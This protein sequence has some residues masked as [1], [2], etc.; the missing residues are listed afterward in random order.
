MILRT[1]LGLVLIGSVAACA[2]PPDKLSIG[3]TSAAYS[4]PPAN[5]EW[6]VALCNP[7]DTPAISAG[8]D[9]AFYSQ[10]FGGTGLGT[11]PHYWMAQSYFQASINS[12]LTQWI[13][14]GHARAW[15]QAQSR[16]TNIETCVNAALASGNYS[17]FNF[18]NY[19]AVYNGQLDEGSTTANIQGKSLPA[20][21]LDAYSP[22]SAIFHEMGHG[23]GLGH[24]YNDQGT[25]YGDPYD[26]MSAMNVYPFASQYCVSTGGW[27]ACDSGPGLNAWTRRQL[28]WLLPAQRQL[29]WPATAGT[30]LRTQSVALAP[31]NE[32]PIGT[33]QVL[34]I[35]A[36]ASYMYTV[37]WIL[38]DNYDLGNLYAANL[39]TQPSRT[40]TNSLVIHK[41]NYGDQTTYL[42]TGAG[43][44]QTSPGN[45]FYDSATG[46]HIAL[47]GTSFN[48]TVQVT[49]D[50]SNPVWSSAAGSGTPPVDS[51][52][53]WW[54]GIAPLAGD[55]WGSGTELAGGWDPA[56]GT[57]YPCRAWY[58][59]GV[60]LGKA[61][62]SGQWCAFPW[63]GH[64]IFASPAYEVLTLQPG[65]QA[66]WVDAANGNLPANALAAGFD[67]SNTLHVCRAL[68]D[69]NWT[70]GKF[71]WGSCDVSWG[72][73]ELFNSLYQVLTVQ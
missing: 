51:S 56:I 55:Q 1:G 6:L 66:A 68:V 32:P 25:E 71:I 46:V 41:I 24:S 5:T 12:T 58:G 17:S 70:P 18:Y 62:L 43:G 16:E 53:V 26:V 9:V 37:E 29:W 10:F 23:F 40:P 19:I 27:Y 11:V 50:S 64:E 72:G 73:E 42:V 63:G 8:R 49:V 52:K 67:G 54:Q 14:T 60:H 48:A 7:T 39:P 2:P 65:A 36:S 34:Y 21:I 44:V 15:H 57:L 30:P 13:S 45:P 22:P 33:P 4:T 69:G 47:T 61:T 20:V 38:A 28:G 31:R 3:Q 35:P 59:G